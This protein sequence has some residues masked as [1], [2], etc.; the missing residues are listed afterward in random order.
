MHLSR[1]RLSLSLSLSLSL[2][3]IFNF[4]WLNASLPMMRPS[5]PRWL[6]SKSARM[7]SNKRSVRWPPVCLAARLKAQDQEPPSP[8][9]LPPLRSTSLPPVF[10][11]LLPAFLPSS[12]PSLCIFQCFLLSPVVLVGAFFCHVFIFS[13]CRTLIHAMMTPTHVPARWS[14]S[15]NICKFP[16]AMSIFL[17]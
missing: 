10:P 12:S 1:F 11:P 2:V 7:H 15:E 9:R 17:G 8:R 13:V 5:P 6:A 4:S 14:I 3:P 16:F